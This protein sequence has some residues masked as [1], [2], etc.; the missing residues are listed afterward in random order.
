M[1][2]LPVPFGRRAGDERPQRAQ[3]LTRGRFPVQAVTFSFLAFELLGVFQEL[4][5][6][7]VQ[8][9]ILLLGIHDGQTGLDRAELILADPAAE[10]F[11]PALFRLE[12]PAA[13]RLF[14]IGTGMGQS[15]LPT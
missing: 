6:V 4:I 12:E 7:A 3:G 14:T 15:S 5:G 8:D 13:C 1:F 11:L 9:G 2:G 10:D